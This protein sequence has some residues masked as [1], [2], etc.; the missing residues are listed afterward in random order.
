MV[1]ERRPRVTVIRVYGISVIFAQVNN[2][3]ESTRFLF[4]PSPEPKG[5]RAPTVSRHHT[6]PEYPRLHA[7]RHFCSAKTTSGGGIVW[8]GGMFF[9]RHFTL[10]FVD[11]IC[12]ILWSK[13]VID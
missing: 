1:S 9:Q 8:G 11:A 7:I 2:V 6:I 5:T 12:I 4:R 3:D 13:S 10:F